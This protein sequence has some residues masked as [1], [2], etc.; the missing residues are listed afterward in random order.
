MTLALKLDAP[1]SGAGHAPHAL[2]RD[3]FSTLG[4]LRGSGRAEVF[5]GLPKTA[6]LA[7]ELVVIK[8]YPALLAGEA[9]SREFELATMLRHENLVRVLGNGEDEGR[10]F[11]VSEYLEGT[12]LERLLRWLESRGQKLPNA[13][14]ARIL[15]GMF[16]AVEHADRW[17][18]AADVRALV[19]QPITSDDI[20]ITYEGDVRLL[21]FKP[22][23]PR[24]AAGSDGTVGVRPAV[25][26][27]LQS[28]RSPELGALLARI[29]K[30]VSAASVL[31]LWQIARALH[32]W[33]ADELQSDGRGELASAMSGVF[34]E[35]RAAR[36]AQLEAACNRVLRAREETLDAEGAGSVDAPPA[37]GFRPSSPENR[38][39]PS[40]SGLP[41][42]ERRA[43]L[44]G[45]FPSIVVPPM[46]E[47]GARHLERESLLPLP[48]MGAAPFLR[49]G[50]RAEIQ[51]L[52]L[53]VARQLPVA[54][55]P[56]RARS[57]AS[58]LPLAALLLTA[59]ATLIGY[60]LHVTRTEPPANVVPTAAGGAADGHSPLAPASAT[61]A[62]PPA[63]ALS[64]PMLEG[65]AAALEPKAPGAR[66][67]SS[68]PPLAAEPVAPEKAEAARVSP[69]SALVASN[70]RNTAPAPAPREA[71]PAGDRA[72]SS[73]AP[74]ALAPTSRAGY[75][76]LDTTPW[77]AV[78]LGKVSLGQTP[79]VRVEVPPGRY[80]LALANEELG[81]A[82]SVIV[83]IVSGETTVRRIGLEAPIRAARR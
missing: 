70:G 34:P 22:M 18:R 78:T 1:P 49:V 4:K 73:S 69:A 16:A 11:I 62:R 10:P 26:D 53:V 3:R 5:V 52:A 42:S 47:L 83:D 33:Q 67:A 19:H 17:V 14:L 60:R 35:R 56:K 63:R 40:E 50:A 39:V 38:L 59:L 48:V 13:G 30:R 68:N 37:S 71:A 82:S 64:V 27:L 41:A 44:A 77:T 23:R 74:A 72:R 9:I 75:L 61:E 32:D 80:E 20:F 31:G 24:Q 7:T 51:E 46:T 79:L 21:G 58:W 36:R 81:I 6:K 66:A 15:L 65:S 55:A 54:P 28:Q 25:D 76:T 57:G 2:A 29:G 43:D 12:T 45:A 8:T